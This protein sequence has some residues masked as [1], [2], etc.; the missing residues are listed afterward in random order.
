[1][2]STTLSLVPVAQDD[3]QPVRIRGGRLAAGIAFP[4]VG[5]MSAG[6]WM[7]I[8]SLVRGASTLF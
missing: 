6:L 2:S 5:L 1:M 3:F 8:I 7:G 4:L